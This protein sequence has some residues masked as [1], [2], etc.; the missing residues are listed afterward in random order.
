[1]LALRAYVPVSSIITV[2]SCT[3]KMLSSTSLNPLF[4][5]PICYRPHQTHP[6][7]IC[8]CYVYLRVFPAIVFTV[9]L[10]TLALYIG[11][12]GASRILHKQLLQNVLRAPLASFFDVTPLGRV[13]NRFSKDVDTTDTD[14]PATLRAWSAC[15]FG[16]PCVNVLLFRWCVGFEKLGSL[17]LEASWLFGTLN[18]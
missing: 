4:M 2:C 5:Y 8:V 16:V 13:L 17:V 3:F 14:L 11:A 12:L 15:F 9:L 1:M 10:S 6:V 18:R 7:Y